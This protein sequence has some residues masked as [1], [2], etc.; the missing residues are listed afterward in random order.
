MV[1]RT[2]SPHSV[3]E[4]PVHDY[5]PMKRV[6]V[7]V[8]QSC[9]NSNSISPKTQLPRIKLLTDN[10]DHEVSAF[11]KSVDEENQQDAGYNFFR[12]PHP[13]LVDKQGSAGSGLQESITGLFKKPFDLNK[14][15]LGDVASNL[16]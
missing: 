7:E 3:L 8:N 12:K 15:K 14:C 9:M 1:K 5:M 10:I 2:I 11:S 16:N 6:K 4:S 13:L